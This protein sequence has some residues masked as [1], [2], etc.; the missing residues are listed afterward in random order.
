MNIGRLFKIDPRNLWAG[1][2][3]HFTPWLAREE[4]ISLL[5]DTIGLELEVVSE[6]RNV[7]PFRADIL[8]RNTLD[9][10][11]V[12]IENQLER[13]DH[14]HL[15]QLLTYAAGL[16]A[17]TIIWIARVFTEE[18][19]AALDWLNRMTNE[20]IRFFGIEL[21]VY[22]IGESDPAP[23]FQ[24]VSKPN[25]WTKA[26]QHTRKQ[27][28]L[29]DAKALN[30]EYWSAMRKFFEQSG[31]RIKVQKPQAQHWMTFSIGRSDLNLATIASVRDR[32][33]RVEFSL[34]GD[35]AKER[36]YEMKNKFE[37]QSYQ[38]LGENIVWDELVGKQMSRVYILIE[39]EVASRARWP[40][41]FHWFLNQLESFD[42]FFRPRIK[43][44]R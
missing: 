24:L 17:V 31:T 29:S 28:E 2:S 7:G 44:I 10:S 34:L 43:Q 16:E 6:E 9:G 5:S 21:E 19:R 33:I 32:F 25:D 4:N 20:D 14:T 11:Y 22:R 41:Q 27:E 3:S 37:Q 39:A 12:L 26:V 38:E 8:C 13:T 42:A 23:F 40:E 35:L 15:G 30:L 1:E 18:H 36:F